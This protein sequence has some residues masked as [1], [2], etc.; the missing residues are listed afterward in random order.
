MKQWYA[1]YVSLYAYKH[2]L[3]RNKFENASCKMWAIK[4]LPLCVYGLIRHNTFSSESSV[5]IYIYVYIYYK[6][7]EVPY[8]YKVIYIWNPY[9]Y[10]IQI[11]M[12]F[13]YIWMPYIYM[14]AIYIL[15]WYVY[16]VYKK[17]HHL[18]LALYAPI[19]I[20]VSVSNPE[21]A[22]S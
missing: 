1:L 9:I 18:N 22:A 3:H 19:H 14:A 8:I 13:I 2:W 12:K 6:D 20:D 7:P 4:F 21:P 17:Y 15:Q 10:T 5:D 11:Y 16:Y